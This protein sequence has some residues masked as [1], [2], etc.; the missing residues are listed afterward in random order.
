MRRLEQEGVSARKADA[1]KQL[2]L[3][4]GSHRPCLHPP[5]FCS[6]SSLSFCFV[7]RGQQTLLQP[8]TNAQPTQRTF[9]GHQESQRKDYSTRKAGNSCLMSLFKFPWPFL[10][11]SHWMLFSLAPVY[12]ISPSP[13]PPPPSLSPPAPPAILSLHG[14]KTLLD[15][16][17][18]P[19]LSHP[20]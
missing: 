7:P 13:L 17:G 15:C 8:F 6:C 1:S 16:D 10:G 2:S 9:P 3:I 18:Q 5:A 19:S 4:F 20:L 12:S 14:P 11:I